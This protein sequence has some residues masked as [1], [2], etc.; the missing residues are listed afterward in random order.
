M[1]NLRSWITASP[2]IGK[3]P[4]SNKELL[5]FLGDVLLAFMFG[6]VTMP[7]ILKWSGLLLCWCILL[8]VVQSSIYKLSEYPVKTRLLG[9]ILVTIAFVGI[10]WPTAREEWRAEQAALPEGN[11]VGAGPVIEDGKQHGFPMVQIG[12]GTNFVMTPDGVSDIFPFFKD[13]GVKIEWGKTGPLLTT[14]VRDRNGN[15][16]AEITR[17]HWKV[18]SLYCADKNYAKDAIEIKDS[19]GHVIL[20][21][22]ILPGT[23]RIQGE[24]WD[25]QGRGVRMVQQPDPKMGSMVIPMNRQ[26]QFNDSLIKPIFE[27][28]SK[29]H[30]GELATN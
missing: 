23:I 6:V 12:E 11:L 15:L 8:F 30:W 25:T 4:K 24:W 3:D 17:N 27:Y 21:V 9:S 14:I 7:V 26:N 22:R 18:C 20:Q 16:V 29:E 19:A 2:R 10:F 1:A 5:F 13:A 28:S